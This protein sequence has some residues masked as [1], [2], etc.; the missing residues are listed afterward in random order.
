MW[1]RV[2]GND[3]DNP[4]WLHIDELNPMSRL[5]SVLLNDAVDSP[6]RVNF[7]RDL[8]RSVIAS[9]RCAS[10]ILIGSTTMQEVVLELER[11]CVD[12]LPRDVVVHTTFDQRVYD[13]CEQFASAIDDWPMMRRSMRASLVGGRCNWDVGP[14]HCYVHLLSKPDTHS[15]DWHSRPMRDMAQALA[16]LI[17]QTQRNISSPRDLDELF[18]ELE[19][20]KYGPFWWLAMDGYSD[21]K[22]SLVNLL[23][24]DSPNGKTC[25]DWLKRQHQCIPNIAQMIYE[26]PRIRHMLD[27]TLKVHRMRIVDGDTDHRYLMM[28]TMWV[29]DEPP[30]RRGTRCLFRIDVH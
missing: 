12:I 29:F 22:S 28:P 7:S 19:R 9:Q 5:R 30:H 14:F 10:H 27:Q 16:C 21:E 8:L 20:S 6:F 11:D 15:F 13:L 2:V 18:K 26:S 24:N 4:V 23:L 3:D 1:R 17:E 25:R